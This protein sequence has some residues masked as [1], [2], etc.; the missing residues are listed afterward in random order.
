MGLL[1]II[2]DAIRNRQ[3]AKTNSNRRGITE[4]KP[5][6]IGGFVEQYKKIFIALSLIILMLSA[7]VIQATSV[8][9]RWLVYVWLQPMRIYL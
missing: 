5:S 9:R 7:L 8:V 1:G 4:Y 3:V 2:S 6:Q